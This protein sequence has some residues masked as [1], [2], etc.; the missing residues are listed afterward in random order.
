MKYVSGS[1]FLR[2]ELCALNVGRGTD[3]STRAAVIS[4]AAAHSLCALLLKNGALPYLCAPARAH[5]VTTA[6]NPCNYLFFPMFL[7]VHGD[8][9]WCCG[10]AGI[11][12]LPGGGTSV[13][14]L[15]WGAD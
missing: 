2:A 10:G 1:I 11:V 6:R 14:R 12:S 9:L 8:R 7:S 5:N 3:L 4:H 15:V 13:G